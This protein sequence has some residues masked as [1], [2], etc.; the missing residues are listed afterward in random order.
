MET[1]IRRMMDEAREKGIKIVTV[2][3]C[4]G[5]LIGKLLTDQP[6][7]SEVYERGYITYSNEGK[8]DLVDVPP[9]L[10]KQYG[11]VSEQVACAMAEGALH[12]TPTQISVSVTG[13]AGPG[14]GSK[15]KPVGLVYIGLSVKEG[16]NQC[17]KCQFSGSRAEVRQKAAEKAIQMLIDAV[18]DYRLSA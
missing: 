7:A 11:A 12:R 18:H 14:G 6:G 13:I 3:S 5:G 10:L 15:D 16:P 1:A 4:T 9:S 17:Q 8:S 2:E